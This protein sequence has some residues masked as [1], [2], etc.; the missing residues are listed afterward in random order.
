MLPPLPPGVETVPSSDEMLAVVKL[1][2]PLDAGQANVSVRVT[3]LFVMFILFRAGS[4]A[5]KHS[6]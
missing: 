5:D 2:T 6:R 1:N 3:E 4:W